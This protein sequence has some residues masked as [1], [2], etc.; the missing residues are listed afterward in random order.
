VVVVQDAVVG[1]GLA[2]WF[3]GDGEISA[4]TATDETHATHSVIFQFY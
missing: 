2:T 3:I 4:S 1:L